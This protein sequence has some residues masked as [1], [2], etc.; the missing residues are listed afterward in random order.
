MALSKQK[1][2]KYEEL[3]LL[4]QDHSE[5]Y[6]WCRKKGL[7]GDLGGPCPKCQQGIITLKKNS[8]TRDGLVWRCTKKWCTQTYSIRHRSWFSN[9]HLTIEQILKI[10][11]IW[12]QKLPQNYLGQQLDLSC[13]TTVDWY[14]M[15]REVCLCILE[16]DNTVIGGPGCTVEID[17]S[18]FGKRKFHRGRRVDG[19]WVFGGV[20]RES[21]ESFF[22]VV[23]KRDA[24]TL[25]PI[26]QENI[27][28]GTT[29]ISD[30]WKAYSR[31]ESLGYNHLTVNHSKEFVDSDTG[32]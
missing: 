28:E 6:E 25:I 19:C 1:H 16:E 13:R 12:C 5:V 24:E 29:I 7:L 4:C 9:S 31:L 23:E 20:E 2:F 30:C 11:Y 22:K 3:I 8:R 27:R 15:C 14:A 17:E 18:K 21:G 32:K 26:I 10:T